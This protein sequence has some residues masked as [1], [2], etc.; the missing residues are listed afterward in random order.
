MCLFNRRKHRKNVRT[1]HIQFAGCMKEFMGCLS[2]FYKVN[3]EVLELVLF[4]T[5]VSILV[6]NFV[7]QAVI[8]IYFNQ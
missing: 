7:E 1:T 4:R 6:R 5:I 3:A 2:L 8:P